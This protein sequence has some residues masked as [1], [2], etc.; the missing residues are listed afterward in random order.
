MTT[1]CLNEHITRKFRF[2]IV[3]FLN[4]VPFKHGSL[5]SMEYSSETVC[6]RVLLLNPRVIFFKLCTYLKRH[7]EYICILTR[8]T[9]SM[10]FSMNFCFLDLCIYV[11]KY[12]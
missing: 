10:S 5:A 3:F 6:Q 8:N 2:H 12:C 11:Y 9:D 1:Q 7:N 4:F